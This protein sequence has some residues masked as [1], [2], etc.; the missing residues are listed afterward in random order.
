MNPTNISVNVTLNHVSLNL[1]NSGDLVQT[2]IFVSNKQASDDVSFRL[3][4]SRL[5]GYSVDV[6]YSKIE[7]TKP[8][9][10][11]LSSELSTCLHFPLETPYD[12]RTVN[13]SLE[14]FGQ[15]EIFIIVVSVYTNDSSYQFK[16]LSTHTS[17]IGNISEFSILRSVVSTT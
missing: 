2:Y 13:P 15:P 7:Y 9:T 6:D 5:S 12:D 11:E 10:P 1:L 3:F 17:E 4:L 16:F 8:E 14:L